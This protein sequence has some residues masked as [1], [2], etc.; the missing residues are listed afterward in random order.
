M[1]NYISKILDY[2]YAGTSI[3]NDLGFG[4]SGCYVVILYGL[5]EIEV[6]KGFL[7]LTDALACAENLNLPWHWGSSDY[8]CN[9]SLLDCNFMCDNIY[10]K[11]LANL[12]T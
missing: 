2:A 5:C 1:S 9:S 4:A 12:D 6:L 8:D 10:E 7:H 3:A 11:K